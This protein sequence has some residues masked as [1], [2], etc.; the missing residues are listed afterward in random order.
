MP[1][2]Y[3][4]I[5]PGERNGDHFAR[6]RPGKRDVGDI[7]PVQIPI[8]VASQRHAIS[9]RKITT[10]LRECEHYVCLTLKS[11]DM[12]DTEPANFQKAPAD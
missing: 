1:V 6:M 3:E 2:W 9:T 4:H 10:A 8:D 12:L 7:L 5:Y 11:A